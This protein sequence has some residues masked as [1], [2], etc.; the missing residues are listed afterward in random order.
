M[1]VSYNVA[2]VNGGQLVEQK[3]IR[4][5]IRASRLPME[6]STKEGIRRGFAENAKKKPK[7]S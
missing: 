6:Y 1:H 3:E 7:V 4:K 5:T 2:E